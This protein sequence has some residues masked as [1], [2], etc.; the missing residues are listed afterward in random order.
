MKL[1]FVCAQYVLLPLCKY[2]ALTTSPRPEAVEH[3]KLAGKYRHV[4]VSMWPCAGREDCD[5]D[6]HAQVWRCKK[7]SCCIDNIFP[8]SSD[9]LDHPMASLYIR[10]HEQRVL[11]RV[12]YL[13]RKRAAEKGKFRYEGW[14]RDATCWVGRRR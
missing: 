13:H 2:S 10:Q 7:G 3:A 1:L 12:A 5:T 14:R 11:Q 9:L 4:A 8:C 6:H